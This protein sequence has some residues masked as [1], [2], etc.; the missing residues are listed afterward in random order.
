MPVVLVALASIW[1]V[2]GWAHCRPAANEHTHEWL[3]LR[4]VGLP[5][6]PQRLRLSG[7]RCCQSSRSLSGHTLAF[8]FTASQVTVLPHL[9]TTALTAVQNGSWISKTPRAHFPVPRADAKHR[10][11]CRLET[12]DT[13]APASSGAAVRG[14]PSGQA[15][16]ADPRGRLGPRPS[17]ASSPPPEARVTEM[18][19]HQ[20][21]YR[22]GGRLSHG[23]PLPGP[24]PGVATT[25]RPGRSV[26]SADSKTRSRGAR[27]DRTRAAIR[28]PGTLGR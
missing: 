8:T 7:A 5:R 27:S 20:R 18:P 25:R 16:A 9:A 15:T 14:G 2:H 11:A 3:S 28:L 13:G 22:S 1:C 19:V 6:S 4:C 23:P 17:P 21:P 12:P 26:L 10:G 24:V